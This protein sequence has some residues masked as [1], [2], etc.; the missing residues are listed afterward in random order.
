MA[1]PC[2]ISRT[3]RFRLV[4]AFQVRHL[5]V[6]CRKTVKIRNS[7]YLEVQ[8]RIVCKKHNNLVKCPRLVSLLP[9]HRTRECVLPKL[10]TGGFWQPQVRIN[11][12]R[13][14]GPLSPLRI[15]NK[16]TFLL[17]TSYRPSALP[18]DGFIGSHEVRPTAIPDSPIPDIVSSGRGPAARSAKTG[19]CVE[20]GGADE[21]LPGGQCKHRHYSSAI[22]ATD[23]QC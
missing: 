8:I 19:C 5:S 16:V 22:R 20:R 13:H 18:P 4:W 15:G 6:Q 2:I 12:F 1:Q 14:P 11:P 9:S 17:L 23:R 10:G 21:F 3:R 7:I